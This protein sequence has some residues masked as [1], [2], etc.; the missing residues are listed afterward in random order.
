M[1]NE[2][3]AL[4]RV[5]GVLLDLVRDPFI[6]NLLGAARA[7][8]LTSALAEADGWVGEPVTASADVSL[9]PLLDPFAHDPPAPGA[10]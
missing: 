1:T 10:P 5:I 7:Q 6:G 4:R 2:G 8:E 9:P 3:R